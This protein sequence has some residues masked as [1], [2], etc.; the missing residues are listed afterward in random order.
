MAPIDTWIAK[1]H[2]RAK[3]AP[4]YTPLS[5]YGGGK[6]VAVTLGPDSLIPRRNDAKANLPSGIKAARAKYDPP[7]R[8]TAHF[9]A[10]HLLNCDLGG[11]GQSYENMTILT[12]SANTKMTRLDNAL[13]RATEKLR[14]AYE[15]IY[16]INSRL[17]PDFGI[18]VVISVS[19]AKWGTLSPDKYIAKAVTIEAE[20]VGT[21]GVKPVP[22]AI[23]DALLQVNLQL[24]GANGRII[25]AKVRPPPPDKVP[26]PKL[27]ALKAKKK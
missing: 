17:E 11:N 24:K 10:G 14:K 19:S 9:K 23:S 7:G 1:Q 13:K 16:Q 6:E 3:A 8:K 12:G 26:K 20:L 27:K 21:L 18:D 22:K 2:A 25:N 4:A 15:V 5:I